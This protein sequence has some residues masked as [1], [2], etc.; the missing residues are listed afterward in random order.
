MNGGRSRDDWLV[1]R[2]S[3]HRTLT[4]GEAMTRKIVGWLLIIVGI[5][6]LLGD[7]HV[8]YKTQSSAHFINTSIGL[9]LV[10]AGLVALVPMLARE[11]AKELANY[12]QAVTAIWPGGLRKTDPP[13]DPN[14]PPPPSVTGGP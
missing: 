4:Y 8:A 2:T 10:L 1:T 9:V 13:P 3:D 5:V 7:F 12:G 11:I 6:V 14:V